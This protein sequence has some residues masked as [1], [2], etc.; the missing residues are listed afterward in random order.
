MELSVA[1]FSK[2]IPYVPENVGSSTAILFKMNGCHWCD[3]IMPEFQ[4]LSREI[5]FMK[6]YTFTV[7]ASNDNINHWHKIQRSMKNSDQ[8]NG[9][10]LVMMFNS[11]TGKV[12]VYPGYMPYDQ[13]KNN[14]IKF[15]SS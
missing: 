6:L 8:L 7:D 12:I 2:R 14:M 3:K 4:R 1:N 9:F 11:K 15:A 13:M 10:P 5:A